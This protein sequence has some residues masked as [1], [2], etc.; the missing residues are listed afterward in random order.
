MNLTT[1]RLGTSLKST[2][3]PLPSS[4]QK[5]QESPRSQSPRLQKECP[6]S[7][8]SPRARKRS[9]QMRAHLLTG[10]AP[11]PR[12]SP[13]PILPRSLAC[14]TMPCGRLRV[15]SAGDASKRVC[16]ICQLP[17]SI[18]ITSHC[19]EN[20]A[21]QEAKLATPKSFGGPSTKGSRNSR[22]H[23]CCCR[24]QTYYIRR[25]P[26]SQGALSWS[27]PQRRPESNSYACRTPLTK[28]GTSFSPAYF[29]G[30]PD[31]RQQKEWLRSSGTEQ[32]SDPPSNLFA[33]SPVS[34]VCTCK[35]GRRASS[36]KLRGASARYSPQPCHTQRSGLRSFS[37]PTS[38]EP[39]SASNFRETSL[40]SRTTK[41][42]CHAQKHSVSLDETSLSLCINSKKG[43]APTSEKVTST[44]PATPAALQTE[45]CSRAA[46]LEFHAA[47]H[48]YLP[49]G[50]TEPTTTGQQYQV[51]SES[52]NCPHLSVPP[53]NG[54]HQ[55]LC[56]NILQQLKSH[57]QQQLQEQ[58]Q[59]QLQIQIQQLQQSMYPVPPC[60]QRGNEQGDLSTSQLG[61]FQNKCRGVNYEKE[62]HQPH[63]CQGSLWHS[64]TAFKRTATATLP[65]DFVAH[66]SGTHGLKRCFSGPVNGTSQRWDSSSTP[67]P[68]P[69]ACAQRF[70]W[71]HGW[72]AESMGSKE[73]ELTAT[74]EE[75]NARHAGT[76]TV[77]N[78]KS[79]SGAIVVSLH[80][81]LNTTR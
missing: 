46:S 65:T 71:L 8:S 9:P 30:V 35:A 7:R 18:S 1:C 50:P 23:V 3:C 26:K 61:R 78:V 59:Q 80:F 14:N 53:T 10:A 36:A 17:K 32:H 72:S 33:A 81:E 70:Q 29:S 5:V 22:R 77:N 43:V 20:V 21:I 31:L 40:D 4:L 6:S 47:T 37:P 39:S 58:V 73:M 79:Y 63:Q 66:A 41:K 49:A 19:S 62:Q 27:H 24:E 42:C 16:T 57:I 74:L 15:L 56:N 69:K 54:L 25:S 68:V 51:A 12:D 38:S 60:K 48:P 76:N 45:P 55:M 28:P 75:L 67:E 34:T 52:I 44:R 64:K 11:K 13:K 2:V